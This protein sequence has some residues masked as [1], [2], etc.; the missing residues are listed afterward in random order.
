[1]AAAAS[2]LTVSVSKAWAAN[3]ITAG[4]EGELEASYV[5]AYRC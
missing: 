2:V 5:V 3:V 4:G 1:V